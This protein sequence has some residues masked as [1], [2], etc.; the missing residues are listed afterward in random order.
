M[1]DIIKLSVGGR[2]FVTKRC[3]LCAYPDSLLGKIFDP[4]SKFAR[5]AEIDGCVF[6]DRDPDMFAHVLNYLRGNSKYQSE[7]CKDELLKLECEADYYSLHDLLLEV[8]RT[9]LVCGVVSSR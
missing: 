1:E 8:K 9:I 2:I 5:P 3:T 4:D 7:L 6:I